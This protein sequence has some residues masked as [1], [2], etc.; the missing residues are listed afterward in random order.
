MLTLPAEVAQGALASKGTVGHG[1]TTA[2]VP[3]LTFGW[4]ALVLATV[5]LEAHWTD[6]A[7]VAT[8]K[9]EV[10][11]AVVTAE[12]MTVV[13]KVE[14]CQKFDGLLVWALTHWVL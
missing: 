13:Q 7:A 9:A 4:T 11:S 5:A 12:I 1:H 10:H 2:T 6:A 8:G 14:W 3:T